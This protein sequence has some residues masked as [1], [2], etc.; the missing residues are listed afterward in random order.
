[1]IAVPPPSH[2]EVTVAAS[3]HTGPLTGRLVVFLSKD[4]TPEPRLVLSLRGPAVFGADITGPT[5]VI[6][7][8]NASFPRS[9]SALPP[10]DYYAQ[11]VVNVYEQVH[12]S[13]GHT[14]WVHMNDGTVEFFN[15][16]AGNLYSDVQRVHLGRGPI[17]LTV[18]HVM[19]TTPRPPDTEWLKHVRMQSAMLT[20]FWGRPVFV[21][22]TVLLPKGYE[23]HPNA[24]YPSVYSLGHGTT[25]FGFTTDSTDRER[26]PTEVRRGATI[27]KTSGLESGYDFYKAWTADAFPRVIAISLE[28]QTPYFPDSYSV[29]SANN[30]PYG[31][32]IITEAMP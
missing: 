5:G 13:D 17:R 6:T 29:N 31:D 30:G 2:I 23:Q 1:M 25:P 18:T 24:Y 32:A 22:A 26:G 3:A 10:G 11:A 21:N 15:T 7:D 16:A 4:S 14:I 20:K 28:Q 12:R 8:T 9:L 19:A 27:G